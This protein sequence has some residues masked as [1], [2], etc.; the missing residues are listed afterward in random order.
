MQIHSRGCSSGLI[1][2]DKIISSRYEQESVNRGAGNQP[3]RQESGMLG[4]YFPSA[5]TFDNA[6]ACACRQRKVPGW[7]QPMEDGIRSKEVVR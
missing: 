6:S 7:K 3:E 2:T 4:R 5:L 1:H